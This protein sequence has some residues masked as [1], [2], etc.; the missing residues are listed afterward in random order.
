MTRGSLFRN[1]CASALLVSLLTACGGGGGGGSSGEK[2]VFGPAPGD[3]VFQTKQFGT[4]A[5]DVGYGI[6]TDSNGNVYVTGSTGGNLGNANAGSEDIFITKYNSQGTKL[7]TR[8]IGTTDS[9][10]GNRVTVDINDN[11][12]IVG[13]TRGSLDG[14]TYAGE[15]DIFIIKYDSDGNKIWTRQAGTTTNDVGT[16]IATDRSGNIYITGFTFGGING[17]TNAG[18]DD[19]FIIKYDANGIE[20]WTRQIG[21]PA[22]DT[23]YGIATDIAGNVYVTGQTGGNFDGNT[24]HG[25]DD[26]FVVKYNSGGNKQWAVLLGSPFAAPPGFDTGTG[27]AT[28][29]NGNIYI[30]GYTNGGLDGN[31][32]TGDNDLVVVKL[33]AGGANQWTRQLGTTRSEFPTSIAIDSNNNIYVTGATDDALDGNAN[34]G[35][36]DL[37]VVKYTSNGDKQWV[38]QLGTTAFDMAWDITTDQNGNAY[39]TGFTNGNLAGTNAGSSTSDAFIIKYD[40][41]GVKQ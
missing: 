30:T 37:F 36:F 28:D 7:W 29:S 22:N 24:N 33:D 38:R 3:T 4:S 15:E 27:I 16:G 21:T 20:Q 17:N 19:T 32:S 11:V 31:V 41:N 5:N 13:S 9:D 39:V 40:S 2:P 23:A 25:G 26:I 6:A 12:Y 10:N 35:D 14:N 1:I 18:T 8:Q 34:A